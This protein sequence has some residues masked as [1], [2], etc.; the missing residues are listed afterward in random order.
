MIISHKALKGDQVGYQNVF[1]R[2]EQK[3]IISEQQSKKIR[4]L[5]EDKMHTDRYG[6]SRICNL[7]FD[8]PDFLLVRR[9]IEKPIF[10]EKLR[11]RSYGIAKPDSTVFAEIKRKYKGVVYKRRIPLSEK[12]I[13][14]YFCD[15][16]SEKE[17]QISNEINY[18]LTLYPSLRARF[19][20]TYE[21]EAF[22]GNDDPDFR[23][24]LDEN[25]FWRTENLSLCSQETGE[26]ILPED[27]VL[28]EI[29]SATAIPLWL[30]AFLSE[31]KIFKTSFSKY[32]EAYKAFLNK[33]GEK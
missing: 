6:K 30:T 3:Y 18:F 14:K 1:K 28:M 12:D 23:L 5:I 10:K 2:L 29:K 4:Q 24:T 16:S 8:T 20:I 22:Y 32:G 26:R 19:Y 13:E 33:K 25:L 11:I 31:E 17:D 27:T 21:R 7:Y 15:I 9:S